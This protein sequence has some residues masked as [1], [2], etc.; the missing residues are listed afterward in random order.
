[1][2]DVTNNKTFGSGLTAI[3][4]VR[5]PIDCILDNIFVSFYLSDLCI[6]YLTG[7]GNMT[8]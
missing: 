5:K 2:S 3:T 8:L 1:M 7:Y 4:E 6:E